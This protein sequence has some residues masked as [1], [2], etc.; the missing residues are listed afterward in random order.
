M[1]NVRQ[2]ID[3]VP[4]TAALEKRRPLTAQRVVHLYSQVQQK[5]AVD[6]SSTEDTCQSFIVNST[7]KFR[8]SNWVSSEH[9]EWKLPE[10]WEPAMWWVHVHQ[11]GLQQVSLQGPRLLSIAGPQDFQGSTCCLN[12]SPHLLYPWAVLRLGCLLCIRQ[13]INLINCEL[14]ICATFNSPWELLC[15][16]LFN[17]IASLVP[18]MNNLPFEHKCFLLG[19]GI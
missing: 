14:N 12:T 6:I 10:K 8:K 18:V 17:Y 2:K 1:N 19:T 5:V 3:I 7:W 15:I 13:S 4:R 11:G 16:S 9:S